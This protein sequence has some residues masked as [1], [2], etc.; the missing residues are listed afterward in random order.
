MP[1]FELEH[2]EEHGGFNAVIGTTDTWD[3]GQIRIEPP[4]YVT[5]ELLDSVKDYNFELELELMDDEC[6]VITF[7]EK[8][9]D[10]RPQGTLSVEEN[11]EMIKEVSYELL[12][13]LGKLTSREMFI[14][15]WSKR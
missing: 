10:N 13:T 1:A 3:F 7:Y 9:N 12:E 8:L 11:S 2:R 4:V 14:K 5:P 6:T 15:K